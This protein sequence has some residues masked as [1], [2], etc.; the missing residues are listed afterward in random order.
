MDSGDGLIAIRDMHPFQLAAHYSLFLYNTEQHQIFNQTCTENTDKTDEYRR[1]C[2]KYAIK[3]GRYDARTALPPEKDVEPYPNVGGKVNH[4]FC[5]ANAIF[6][7][8]EHPRWGLMVGIFTNRNIRAGEE[9]F[10]DYGYK[11]NEFPYDVPWYW[12][13]KEE[14]IC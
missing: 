6:S 10:I 4:H 11:L 1:N 3:S 5:E 8:I 13:A 14:T 2:M 7:E 9:I 12:K